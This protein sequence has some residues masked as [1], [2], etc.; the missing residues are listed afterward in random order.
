MNINRN[1]YEEF[2]LLYVD[3]ELSA[4]ERNAVELFVQENVDL[5]EELNMLLQTV[6]NTDAVTFDNKGSLLK[7]E[8]TALQE[9][10]LLYI[11][12]E[13]NAEQK[14]NTERSLQADYSALKELGLLQ[15]TKLQRE[16]IV[17][18][19]KQSLY[20]KESG[21]VIDLPWRRIAAAAVLLGFGTWATISFIKSNNTKVEEVASTGNETKPA[22]TNPGNTTAT[23]AQQPSIVND[24]NTI[25]ATADPVKQSSQK[26]NPAVTNKEQQNI[27]QQ[28]N[29]DITVAPKEIKKPNNNLPKPYSEN[30]N[31]DERNKTITAY[32][33]PIENA[34]GKISTGDR[35]NVAGSNYKSNTDGEVNGY[36]LRANYT[37]GDA[38]NNLS[39]EDDKGKKTK[40]GGFFRKVKRLVERNTNVTNGNGIKVAGFD[41]AIK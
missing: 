16:T 41:I 4:A 38:D 37:E 15:Q 18:A 35:I 3:N 10:L 24:T 33:P 19:D 17:F 20:R 13:L 39:P 23:I 8:F 30:I 1:N 34:T 5:E 32:V 22:A 2:F 40:L 9:N 6:I 21:R 11:D 7:E 27:P 14:L 29:N 25:T 31:N 36:A 12:N 26:N 28:K